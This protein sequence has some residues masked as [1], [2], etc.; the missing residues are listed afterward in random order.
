MKKYEL[1]NKEHKTYWT[2]KG[3]GKD[4]IQKQKEKPVALLFFFKDMMSLQGGRPELPFLSSHVTPQRSTAP[5]EA[6]RM[7]A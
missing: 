6:T 7:T 1:S 5:L 2:W 3:V 4:Q